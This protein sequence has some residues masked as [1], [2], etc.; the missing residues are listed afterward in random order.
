MWYTELRWLKW[1]KVKILYNHK[2]LY[3]GTKMYFSIMVWAYYWPDWC[4]QFL[5]SMDFFSQQ[6]KFYL[7]DLSDMFNTKILGSE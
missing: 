3:G 1:Y 2:H 4:L 5:D 6:L 7:N